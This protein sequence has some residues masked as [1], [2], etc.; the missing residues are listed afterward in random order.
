MILLEVAS[1]KTDVSIKSTHLSSN[2]AGP[3]RGLLGKLI[4]EIG[5]R[6][7]NGDYAPK[8]ALPTE[9]E[10]MT[11]LSVSRT[12]LREA[13]KML[14]AKGL[15]ESRG[16]RGTLVRE[17]KHWNL[18]DPTILQLHCQIVEYSAFAQSFQQIRSVVE[19]EAAA[20]AAEHRSNGQLRLLE[21][22]YRDMES[23]NDIDQWTAADLSFHEAIL[24]ATGNPFMRPLGALISAALETLLFHSAEN[25]SD[26]ADALQ[27]HGR[28]LDAIRNRDADKARAAMKSLLTRTAL[29]VSKSIKSERRQ[30]TARSPISTRPS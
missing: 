22:A 24:E 21:R 28:V 9:L 14:A 5:L 17:R 25:A 19:P 26:T 1:T 10:L 2:H 12:V 29:F 30:R 8:E 13:I 20:L 18:L 4:E 11:E 16:K 6:I 27:V 3:T 23:A 7:L 15:L